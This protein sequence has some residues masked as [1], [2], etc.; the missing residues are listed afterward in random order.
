[1]IVDEAGSRVESIVLDSPADQAVRTRSASRARAGVESRMC[2][3]IRKAAA[4]VRLGVSTNP[5]G[6]GWLRREEVDFFKDNRVARK[7]VEGL[8]A[9]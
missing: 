8:K 3:R 7:Y 9:S 1:V 6:S 2:T 5:L 4:P